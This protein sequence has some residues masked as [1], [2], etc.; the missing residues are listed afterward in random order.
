LAQYD[1]FIS[2]SHAKD[3]PVAG[4]LQAVVQTL[5]KPWYRRRALR[6]FRD[7][8]SLSA[9]PGLW[10]S[11]EQA[12]GQSR[13]L[14]FLASPE[15]AASPW[16]S[17]E[18]AHW[19]E[20]RS[21][22]TLLIALT[23][24]D[25]AW[26][27]VAGDFRSSGVPALPQALKGRFAAE[28]KWVDLRAHRDHPDPRDGR[29]IEAGADF[30]A[31][32]HGLPKEDL[33]SQELRQQR[34]ALSL[35]WSAAGV[36]LLLA[37]TAVWQW[38]AALAAQRLAQ[39]QRDR[40]ER[41]LA[42]ATETANAFVFEM[43]QELRKSQGMPINL[44]RKILDRARG[45]QRQLVESGEIAP[46]L[47]HSEVGA[48]TEL[49]TTLRL[50]G[51]LRAALEAAERAR[52]I[53]SA[54]TARAAENARWQHDLAVSYERIGDIQLADGRREP[55]LE[56][57][58]MNLA[59]MEKLVAS[60][61][62]NVEW[63]GG[64]A[65][66]L[67]NI[68]LVLQASGRAEDA[69]ATNRKSLAIV[70]KLAAA[71]PN[72]QSLQRDL[73]ISYVRI[74]EIL[75]DMG[76]REEALE[77]YGRNVEIARRLA[78]ADPGNTEWQRDLSVSYDKIGNV[79]LAMGRRDQALEVYRISLTIR[80]TLAT[81]D[82]GNTQW[83]RD[84]SLSH[85]RMGDVLLAVGRTAD[86][87]E[88]YRASLAIA[89]TLAAADPRN[90]DWQRDLSVSAGKLGNVLARIGRRDEALASYRRSLAIAEKLAAMDPGNTEW[91][92]DLAVSYSKVGDMLELTGRDEEAL[93]AYRADLAV[94][95]KLVAID[96]R[97]TE[98]QRDLSISYEKLAGILLKTGRRADAVEAFSRARAIRERL[99]AGDPGNAQWQSDL[100]ISL[101][102]AAG[103]GDNP[104]AN[105]SRALDI[106]R[107]LEREGGLSADQRR[108]ID[109]I[110]RELAKLPR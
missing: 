51:D 67:R 59:I 63:Q 42:A 6:V 56:S 86:A 58:R 15:A 55:A 88:S 33:L 69:L 62:G 9:T 16:V 14:I 11:I 101:M 91:Q 22:N 90:A 92:R 44:T 45:L 2:Y 95:E 46:D 38:Q 1:A 107:R 48:L 28:P 25:L 17:K 13:F 78:N 103:L 21:A 20:H 18:V 96:P 99:A 100:V 53:A 93:A 4:A 76:R 77:S 19:L 106:L 71:K 3:K 68:A 43:A 41:T 83:Q 36:L 30:A 5:G 10:P 39:E 64:L 82:R 110:T 104:R 12:L 80:S 70:E 26:D 37:G 102:Q 57:Y 34:R 35:A 40:A 98:W 89:E 29:F 27:S 31:A 109:L 52:E 49:A 75:L 84:L 97:N 24:G 60:D 32:I 23:D 85:D 105:L 50:Q 73:S 54:L 81:A 79:L 72:D 74:G 8:T 65:A 66:T 87:L 108:W 94:S 61:P 7:D 47:L